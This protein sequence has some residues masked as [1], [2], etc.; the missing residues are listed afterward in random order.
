MQHLPEVAYQQY[1]HHQR[2]HQNLYADVPLPKPDPL[3]PS[4]AVSPFSAVSRTFGSG[5]PPPSGKGRR[6]CGCSLLVFLLAVIIAI[7]SAAIIGL[8]ATTGIEA[9]RASD[10]I[11]QVEVLNASLAAAAPKSTGAPISAIDSGCSANATAVTG[12]SYTAFKGTT[13]TPRTSGRVETHVT[14][15]RPPLS[16]RRPPLHPLLQPRLQARPALLPLHPRL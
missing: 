7:L 9:N 15:P 14:N 13:P 6:V 10:A 11:A 1:L 12:T 4:S 3:S 2:H 8:A 16:P 5:Y